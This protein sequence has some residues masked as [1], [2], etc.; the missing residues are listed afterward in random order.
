MDTSPADTRIQPCIV[1]PPA[2][3]GIAQ[4]APLFV[5][6]P[7][8][9][10]FLFDIDGTLLD[11]APTPT[12]VR[13]PSD[14]RASLAALYAASGGAVALVSGRPLDDIDLIFTPLVLPAIGGHGAEFR[15]MPESEAVSGGGEIDPR[16]KRDLAQFAKQGPGILIEDKGYALALHYR[17]VPE[18]E[19]MVR[20]AVADIC[21]AH[22]HA[23][24]EILPGKFVVEIKNEG[25]TKATAVRELMRCPPFAGRTPIFI[26]DDKT[27]ETVFAIMPELD[28]IAFSVGHQA[29][30]VTGYFE[31]PGDVRAWLARVAQSAER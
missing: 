25:F 26:G 10:A 22:P 12:D 1:R 4:A 13:V 20:A 23:A 28:G 15:V 21:A 18:K 16:L 17:R 14:L 11:I 31:T 3:P 7:R 9:F 8:E 24:V 2:R 27:D 5:P 19:A 6:D 29:A 30:G